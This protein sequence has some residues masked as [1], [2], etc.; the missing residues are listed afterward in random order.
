MAF[1]WPSFANLRRILSPLGS[2]DRFSILSILKKTSVSFC[3]LLLFLCFLIER[4]KQKWNCGGGE[5]G[6]TIRF[7]GFLPKFPHVPP[8]HNFILYPAASVSGWG[9]GGKS[10]NEIAG[11]VGQ[12]DRFAGFLPKF[13]HVP[14]SQFLFVS[15]NCCFWTGGKRKMKPKGG[16]Q[17]SN[18]LQN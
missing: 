15:R 10:R 8:P 2:E 5:V 1:P 17:N 12:T 16:R 9:W 7:A 6:K 4:K 3:I 18:F 11:E 14:P 13:P